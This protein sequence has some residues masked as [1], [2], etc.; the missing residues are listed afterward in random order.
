MTEGAHNT[1]P[2]FRDV[3]VLLALG[4]VLIVPALFTRDAWTPD[5]PRYVEVAREMIAR[6]DYLVLHL[7]GAAYSDKP[8]VFFWLTTVLWRLG[9]GMNSGRVVAAVAALAT[10]LLVYRLGRR[11]YGRETGYRAALICLTCMLFLAIGKVGNLDAM[12]TFLVV[13][14]ISC[15]LQA[16]EAR[17]RRAGAWWLGFYAAIAL[18]VLV[19]G[20]VGLATPALVVLTYGLAG[21]R[22]LAGGGWWHLG[23]VL[24]FAALVAAWLVPAALLGGREYAHDL[25]FQQT[26]QRVGKEAIH[27]EPIYAYV[28]Q[29]PAYFFPWS[30]LLPLALVA[31]FREAWGKGD[32]RAWLPVLWFVVIFVFFS[33]IS[34][35]R[36]RYLLPIVP[37]VGLLVARYL[38]RAE[39]EGPRWPDWHR[40]LW[41]ATF[42]VLLVLAAGILASSLFPGAVLGRAAKRS[43]A[44]RD[45]LAS[46]PPLGMAIGAAAGLAL[47]LLALLGLRQRA[48]GADRRRVWLLVG[49]VAVLSLCVDAAVL[50]VVNLRKSARL[51]AAEARSVLGEADE[52]YLLR[53]NFGGVFNL[54]LERAPLGELDSEDEVIAALNTDR[55]VAVVTRQSKMPDG[56]GSPRA[57]IVRTPNARRQHMAFVVNWEQSPSPHRE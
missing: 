32:P 11:L 56:V 26:L 4:A 12:L 28:L 45:F 55:R 39:R 3:A 37:A 25:I 38:G 15:G 9:C 43:A 47:G 29:A 30:L 14:A 51:L 48:A 23:G 17:G 5:E 13:A 36:E 1:P 54:A 44:V 46:L 52:V 16:L 49:A 21:R 53:S 33:L 57:R 34:G 24:L 41:R 2:A 22:Q 27:G 42:A 18:A 20:P 19:K 35:K 10:V 7:N 6:G 31:A 40:G 8:P 50:P